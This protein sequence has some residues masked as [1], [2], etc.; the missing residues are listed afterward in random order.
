M[1]LR[2]GI[3]FSHKRK[4]ARSFLASGE[5]GQKQEKRN[6]HSKQDEHEFGALQKLR[7]QRKG[8]SR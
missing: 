6:D 7:N 4:T 5:V 2:L 3:W 8:L 1:A